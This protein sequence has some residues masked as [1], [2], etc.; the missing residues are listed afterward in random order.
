MD[1][2]YTRYTLIANHNLSQTK[3]H[4]VYFVCHTLTFYCQNTPV[5]C[6]GTHAAFFKEA[7]LESNDVDETLK[8]N[9][10]KQVVLR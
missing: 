6:Y 7:N 9:P 3:L 10:G 4:P 5:F 8:F 1:S 2:E